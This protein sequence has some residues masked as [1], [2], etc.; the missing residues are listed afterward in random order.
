MKV[1]YDKDA[2]LSLIK[3][4]QVTIV[5]YGSQGHAHAQN[6]RDSGV[7]VTVGLRKSGASWAKAAAAGLNVAEV[8]EAVKAADVVMMLLPDETIPQVYQ[9]DVAPNMKAGAALAFAHG[10]NV[11]YN[12][13]VPR[14]DVDVIMIAPK[15]PG[16]TVRSE[17]LKGGGV[18]SLIAVYQDKSG[19]A[20]DIALSY[21][22]ANGGTKGGVIETNFREETETDLFGEQAVLCGGA[23]ELIKAGFETLVEAGYAPQMAYFECLHE[24]KLIVDLIYEGGIANMNYSISNNAEYGEYVTGQRVI[25]GEAR[26][27]MKECLN[28]IQ[29]G[30]YAKQ[31]I[32]EG[33]TNYP[34]MTARRRINAEHPI[35]VVGGQLRAMM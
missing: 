26:A 4:K 5:G 19:K 28:N 25:A 31:F 6:L 13:V 20:R 1:F 22:A 7:N 3:G 9:E 16:H 23:V 8:S 35:E 15:G 12:Q 21:A 17:Y 10:F 24:M 14:A 11:H 34:E 18:P 2:D 32:L 30:N 27:A 29:N 33:R